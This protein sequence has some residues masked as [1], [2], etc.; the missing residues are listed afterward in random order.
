MSVEPF[1]S[2]AACTGAPIS[3]ECTNF[4]TSQQSAI[5]NN[6]IQFKNDTF[7]NVLLNAKQDFDLAVATSGLKQ[8]TQ[9]AA[10]LTGSQSTTD[11]KINNMYNHDIDISK[12]Q[13][14]INEYQYNN[15]LEFLF[16]LQL[17]FISVLVMSILVYFNNT[18]VLTTQMT[19]IA[20]MALALMVLIVGV[21]RY[22]YTR[23]TRDRHLW[24]RRY[25]ANETAPGGDLFPSTCAGPTGVTTI[26]LDSLVDP[27]T[28]RC[29]MEASDAFKKLQEAAQ[30]EVLNQMQGTDASSLWSASLSMGPTSSCK[31]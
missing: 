6:T 28:T 3:A 10:N 31:A 29:A 21:S 23:R 20:S 7:N 8:R 13:F 1:Q 17:L 24:N 14:Q 22:F 5:A 18:G 26:N 4:L 25:F 9:E 27:R 19:A 30:T 11:T 16:F 15:K 12:R 2:I